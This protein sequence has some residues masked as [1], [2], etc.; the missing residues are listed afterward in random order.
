MRVAI[1]L[2]RNIKN[3]KNS[4]G[5]TTITNIDVAHKI[6]IY[7][8]LRCTASSDTCYFVENITIQ[9]DNFYCLNSKENDIY[10]YIYINLKTIDLH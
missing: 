9:M 3:M 8:T 10:I 1:L 6:M 5:N 7:V 4:Y 2:Y